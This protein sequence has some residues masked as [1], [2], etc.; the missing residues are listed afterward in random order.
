MASQSSHQNIQ[1]HISVVKGAEDRSKIMNNGAASRQI[2][3]TA[4]CCGR[5]CNNQSGVFLKTECSEHLLVW[6]LPSFLYHATLTLFRFC[7]TVHATPHKNTQRGGFQTKKIEN[8]WMAVA[9]C[10]FFLIRNLAQD[11]VLKVS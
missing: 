10:T 2:F 3:L 7:T 11:L 9:T 4:F 1:P 5:Y 8:K 6:T